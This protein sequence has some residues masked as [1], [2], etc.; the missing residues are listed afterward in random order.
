MEVEVIC[1]VEHIKAVKDVL[2]GVRVNDVEQ[3]DYSHAVSCV[4]EFFQFFRGTVARTC[5]KET[6]DLV[7]KGWRTVNRHSVE[8]MRVMNYRRSTRAP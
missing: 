6:G 3:D 8:A 4:N 5:G 1:T 2:A 7:S